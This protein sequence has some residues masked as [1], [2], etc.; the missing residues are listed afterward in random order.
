MADEEKDV[1]ALTIGLDD[2]HIALTKSEA[3]KLR[4]LSKH[5]GW[6]IVL[7]ILRAMREGS[8]VALKDRKLTLEDIRFHQGKIASTERVAEIIT[9]EVDQWYTDQAAEGSGDDNEQDDDE[10]P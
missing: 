8:V 4:A 9:R 3:I 5:E 10:S 1:V 2:G 6:P 7:E